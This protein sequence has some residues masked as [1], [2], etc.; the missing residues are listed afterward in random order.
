MLRNIRPY[1]ADIRCAV[2][3]GYGEFLPDDRSDHSTK[4]VFGFWRQ[5]PPASA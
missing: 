4:A 2:L 5:A 3:M 1:A